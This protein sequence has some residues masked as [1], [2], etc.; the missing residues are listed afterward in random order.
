MHIL[1]ENK[2]N[3][4]V[5]S[6][7]SDLNRNCCQ[8]LALSQGGLQSEKGRYFSDQKRLPA[9]S[10]SSVT[11][12][13]S[14]SPNPHFLLLLLLLLSHTISLSDLSTQL[15][16]HS[17]TTRFLKDFSF[18][19]IVQTLQN[20]ISIHLFTDDDWGDNIQKFGSI[21]QICAMQA[22]CSMFCP[23]EMFPFNRTKL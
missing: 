21:A 12:H 17:A 7:L 5:A 16:C 15:R 10:S 3:A 11:M 14:D 4:L 22:T 9:A 23:S 20:Q 19:V 18:L 6:L 2:H 1:N 8:K 13:I